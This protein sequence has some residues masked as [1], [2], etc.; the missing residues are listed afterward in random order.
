MF[1][2]SLLEHVARPKEVDGFIRMLEKGMF[3]E[4]IGALSKC[5]KLLTADCFVK[6]RDP[7]VERALT[8]L[9][10][11]S[12]MDNE[13]SDID[14]GLV[15]LLSTP[16]VLQPFHVEK[17]VDRTSHLLQSMGG[18][19]SAGDIW[20]RLSYTLLCTDNPE[21]T[22]QTNTKMASLS[23]IVL[24]WA[25]EAL[26]LS[27]KGHFKS[28]GSPLLRRESYQ[29]CLA[30]FDRITDTIIK[31]KYYEGTVITPELPHAMTGAIKACLKYGMAHSSDEDCRILER[32]LR[33]IRFLLV[34]GSDPCSPLQKVKSHCILLDAST[35][36]ALVLAHSQFHTTITGR[37]AED[38]NSTDERAVL[39]L[40]RV[41]L[42]CTW[43]SRNTV[44]FES[45]TWAT[46][47]SA[48]NAGMSLVD[49]TLRRLFHV[50]ADAL[51][52][53][54][55]VSAT[56]ANFNSV[57]FRTHTHTSRSRT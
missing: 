9:Y 52:A 34:E 24:A 10:A 17:C 22:I 19:D 20:F 25:L 14:D 12:A 28:S 3:D 55:T 56:E 57:I 30:A 39:E 2:A 13:Q 5:K 44:V 54:D 53:R 50:Y 26:Q 49:I 41:L 18:R 36:L 43:L 6:V 4:E 15:L 32:C 42:V 23:S 33:F 21:L 11:K 31:M 47:L 7:I 48:Y 27:V 1:G 46:L 29:A 37:A 38:D 51:S 16:G 40:V 45:E 35:V 8:A